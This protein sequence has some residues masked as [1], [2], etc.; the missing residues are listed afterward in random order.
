MA[1]ADLRSV[2]G[3]CTVIDYTLLIFW[4]VAFVLAHD[5]LQ[6]LHGR[7]FSIQEEKFDAI[8]YTLMA[9]F[10]LLIFMFNLVPYVSM[11]IIA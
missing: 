7:W 10:K 4:F 2:L 6:R 11:R 9:V 5:W 3:W 1:I 8:H